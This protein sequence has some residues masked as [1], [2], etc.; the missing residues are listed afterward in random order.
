MGGVLVFTSINEDGSLH[1]S[2][3]A[4]AGLAEQSQMKAIGCSFSEVEASLAS[5]F[6]KAGYAK[7][8]SV[9]KGIEL[10]SVRQKALFLKKVIEKENLS[11]IWIYQNKDLA[12]YLTGL[13]N[14]PVFENVSDRIIEGDSLFVKNEI[15]AGKFLAKSKSKKEAKAVISFSSTPLSKPATPT[16]CL[17]ETIADISLE[18]ITKAGALVP[19]E[20]QEGIAL[21][22]AKV[23]LDIGDG[24][25]TKGIPTM[26]KLGNILKVMGVKVAI[27]GSRV[28]TDAGRL[29]RNAQIGISG[30]AVQPDLIISVGVSGAP[31]H[32]AGMK[33]AKYKVCVNTD[34]KAPL[35]TMCD[36]PVVGDGHLFIKEL[37]DALT[38]MLTAEQKDL[39]SKSAVVKKSSE[40]SEAQHAPVA[41]MEH[42]N[43]LPLNFDLRSIY[44]EAFEVYK[45]QEI[46][47]H[48]NE[49]KMKAILEKISK[50]SEKLVNQGKRDAER[51]GIIFRP[52]EEFKEKAVLS[53]KCYHKAWEEYYKSGFGRLATP[54]ALGGLELPHG[55]LDYVIEIMSAGSPALGT[56]F[57]LTQGAALI[58]TTFGSDW[59]KDT[60]LPGLINGRFQGT[61][62]LTEANAGSDLNA[63]STTAVRIPGS[64]IFELNGT[65]IFITSG[66]HDI[67]ENHWHIVL[68][69]IP[70]TGFEGTRAI[71]L[72]LV[73][74]FWVNDEGVIQGFNEVITQSIEH[75][76]GLMTSPTC[77][78]KLNNSKGFLIANNI[79]EE[80][81]SPSGMKKMFFFMNAMRHETGTAGRGQAV[82]TCLD[83]LV[84][85]NERKQ[86][87]AIK[88]MGKKIDQ[89]VIIHH[90]NQKKVLLDMFARTFGDRAL[91]QKLTE[92]RDRSHRKFD[93]GMHQYQQKMSNLIINAEQKK[94][95]EELTKKYVKVESQISKTREAEKRVRKNPDEY[96]RVLKE[97]AELI[98][99]KNELRG[100][101]RKINSKY[102]ELQD[103]K[104]KL[105]QEKEDVETYASIYTSLV[106][107]QVTDDNVK[108]LT[109]GMQA[110]G[111]I[112]FMAETP[113]SQRLHDS[114]ILCIWEGTNDIQS[115]N[116]VFRQ[117]GDDVKD[118]KGN[119]IF[120]KVMDEINL[121]LKDNHGHPR[122]DSSIELL[123]KYTMELIA[124]RNGMYVKKLS[125]KNF[126]SGSILH[127]NI[128][129]MQLTFGLK[130]NPSKA[131]MV[132]AQM[133]WGMMMQSVARSF[134]TYF[135]QAVQAWQLLRIAVIASNH[136]DAIK[137]GAKPTIDKEIYD[138]KFLEGR[139]LV[140]KHFVSSPACL[141]KSIFCWQEF[142]YNNAATQ[143][144][145]EHLA[146]KPSRITMA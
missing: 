44:F 8:F 61:M 21:P 127:D 126:M 71:S 138:E 77:V 75:K 42:L 40:T 49:E 98:F 108:T 74:K 6:G 116:T 48:W 50:F 23:V 141:D 24:L 85:S 22:D 107:A 30:I 106:K 63:V 65:K 9:K 115:L 53:P 11:E 139:I 19:T 94:Q 2:A 5:A 16:N 82:A 109:D 25:G 121:F 95:L 132:E 128:K 45:V 88:D 62:C 73:P 114:Q 137:R 69:K 28:V 70:G 104:K 136:L 14:A 135:S 12:A 144:E 125:F 111:G 129:F 34:S 4:L 33:K 1:G 133:K 87:V 119:I 64:D 117:I 18:N 51:V 7:I 81:R 90:G 36:Y 113:V 60:I 80:V 72:F 124:F 145:Y 131:E 130:L 100:E 37:T 143:L 93:D 134:N 91:T 15:F 26:K 76:S 140:A 96:D 67:T 97:K 56:Y 35:M 29:P 92:L 79:E 68:A 103:F 47:E 31:Q 32:W 101:I 52:G 20:K 41:H 112:G 10:L 17:V 122:L 39:L 54:R 110:Y 59:M 86:G 142:F 99:L 55:L 105:K 120:F 3:I 13:L 57:G 123:K 89:S 43:D 66:D 146:D 46:S 78:I 84:Y 58:V 102:M 38:E 27:G 118:S 83:A